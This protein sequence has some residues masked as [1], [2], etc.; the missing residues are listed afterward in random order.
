MI[1]LKE[2]GSFTYPA[3]NKHYKTHLD[4]IPIN[5]FQKPKYLTSEE[6]RMEEVLMKKFTSCVMLFQK[7]LII[8]EIQ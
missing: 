5:C 7:N 4:T 1:M 8:L 2:T 6:L 3:T